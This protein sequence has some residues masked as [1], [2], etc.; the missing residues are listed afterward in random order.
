M[1][2]HP[3]TRLGG[4]TIFDTGTFNEAAT[5]ARNASNLIAGRGVL[6]TKLEGR[7]VVNLDRQTPPVHPWHTSLAWSEGDQLWKARIVPG[8]VNGKPPEVPA[9][10]YTVT[11]P[12]QPGRP[13]KSVEVTPTLLDELPIPITA[14]REIRGAESGE[15][16]PRYFRDMGVREEKSGASAGG[17]MGVTINLS[18]HEEEGERLLRAADIVLTAY[19]ATYQ[20]NVTFPANIVLANIVDY[21]VGLDISNAFRPADIRAMPKIPSSRENTFFDRLQ[22]IYGDEGYDQI[23]VSTVY[24]V[25]PPKSVATKPLDAVTGE[26]TP[27]VKHSLFWNAGY[28]CEV[29]PPKNFQ[30]LS[31]TGALLFVGRYTL[32]PAAA[33]GA[34][35]AEM[36]RMVAATFNEPPKGVFYT[37]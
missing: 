19:R 15:S 11:E 7:V 31:S 29:E 24:F 1:N 8:F 12:G 6:V 10:R 35:E 14:T 4:R 2:P 9:L 37:A 25:S 16:V 5:I 18:D 17:A 30:Q 33:F 22:G 13:G 21:S 32:A 28:W 36:Q 27:V 34:M 3:V 23:L 26:W 20:M